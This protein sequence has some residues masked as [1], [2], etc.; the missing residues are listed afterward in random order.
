MEKVILSLFD[1]SGHWS[2][3]YEDAGYTI[4]QMDIKQG[5]GNNSHDGDVLERFPNWLIL[6]PDVRVVGIIAAP[7]CT[8]FAGSGARWWA[9]KDVPGSA[10][11]ECCK[12][13]TEHS[14]LLIDTVMVLVEIFEP[15]FWVIEN[16]V[17][18]L[19]KLM[20]WIGDPKYFNP[21]DFS[22]YLDLSDKDLSRLI[23]I[24]SKNGQNITRS[25]WKHIIKCNAYTKKTGLW[26]K[27]NMPK[28]KAIEP[29]KAGG[30][31]IGTSALNRLGGK[32]ERTKELRS[33]TPAGFS[34]AFY[35]ANNESK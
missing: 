9:D 21:C 5:M 11:C 16:P 24:A 3:P 8:D 27:F 14:Q 6:E 7:P 13:V 29:V 10:T 25:E 18:R 31:T 19:S 34:R 26:G 4:V 33:I 20:P 23:K 22:G 30:P 15:D 2:K 28:A 1:H 12:T 35:E 32:S 17:G